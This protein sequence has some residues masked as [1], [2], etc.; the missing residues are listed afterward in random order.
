MTTRQL[1]I[2]L[3]LGLGLTLGLLWALGG[4]SPGVRAA[5]GDVYCVT[6]DGGGPYVGCAQVF[7]NVQAAVDAASGGEEIRVAA[8]A[9]TGVQARKGVTQVVFITATVAIRGGY[10]TTN[11]FAGPPDPVANSTTLDAQGEGRVLYITGDYSMGSNPAISPTI[12]GLRITGGDATGLGGYSGD[13]A[14]GGVYVYLTTATISNCAVT[15][16]TA[17]TTGEGYGGGLFLRSSDAT[18]SGNVVVSNTASM[19]GEGYGGG[20]FLSQSDAAL[21]SDNMVRGN[22]ASEAFWGYGGGLYLSHSDASL[23]GN[24]VQSNTAS[25]NASGWGRGGGLFLFFS[26]A[27]LNDNFVL[28][29][30]ASKASNGYGGGL[31]LQ[32]SAATLNGNVLQGNIASTAGSGSGGGLSLIWEATVTLN[33][34]VVQGNI[35]STVSFGSGGGLD[36]SG[37][38]VILNGNTIVSNTATLS[39]T[40]TGE[41]GGLSIWGVDSFT[42]TNNLVADNHANDEGGGLRISGGSSDPTSGRLLH[43]TIADNRGSGQGVYVW[44]Y[45]TLIFT[46]TIVAGHSS[47]GVFAYTG[48]TVTLE[49]TLWYSNGVDVGGG[50]TVVSSTNVTGD[51]AFVDP[52]AWD[53][54][55]APSSAAI[56]RGVAAGV[57][58]DIDGD[59]RPLDAG[60]DIG[61]D[62]AVLQHRYLPLVMKDAP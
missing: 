3:A 23:S 48:S 60:Y 4:V 5:P 12:E 40:T 58:Y 9:Y 33:D 47:A 7:T 26:D 45:T 21:L 39:P 32:A 37:G 27:S 57:D 30:T 43:N 49:A 62:E 22:V 24:T 52:S 53:Y 13:D 46:N 11:D 20:L 19:A 25:T 34:N 17:S 14:G 15:G 8:G 1:F 41:G 50:S 51:P 2:P 10:T 55:L 18:L 31:Y 6:P 29:N 36:L 28:G 54:H 16:N 61:A 59:S 42:M 38:P 35:A 44:R 56:D